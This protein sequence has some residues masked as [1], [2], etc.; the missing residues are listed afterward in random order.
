M[1]Q[2]ITASILS[3]G[4]AVPLALLVALRAGRM[5]SEF[6]S[7][8]LEG[9]VQELSI[10]VLKEQIVYQLKLLF[11][12][13]KDTTPDV[14]FP[15]GIDLGQ[16]AE[17]LFFREETVLSLNEIHLSLLNHGT[18]SPHFVQALEFVLSSLGGG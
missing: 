13:Y 11:T 4:L 17:G 6:T 8:N 9:K 12:V 2:L 3:L 16:V 15:P 14:N 1:E 5:I 10:T 18:Q 7:L